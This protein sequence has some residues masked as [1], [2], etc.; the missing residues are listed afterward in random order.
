MAKVFCLKHKSN[1]AASYLFHLPELLI[2]PGESHPALTSHSVLHHELQ[3]PGGALAP[4]HLS[5]FSFM[6]FSLVTVFF[7][8]GSYGTCHSWVK[9]VPATGPLHLLFPLTG[10]CKTRSFSVLGLGSSV[11]FSER[12]S[13]ITHMHCWFSL[14]SRT[15]QYEITCLFMIICPLKKVDSVKERRDLPIL[16]A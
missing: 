3:G 14:L 2:P 11:L 9:L 6:F 13:M 4:A 5:I 16:S 10:L 1:H 7:H 15:H 8:C 12:P